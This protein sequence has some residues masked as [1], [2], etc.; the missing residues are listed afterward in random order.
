MALVLLD[1]FYGDHSGSCWHY[2]E[3]VEA[4]V[5]LLL[6]RASGEQ[7]LPAYH[8]YFLVGAFAKSACTSKLS[9]LLS[10]DSTNDESEKS[11]SSVFSVIVLNIS[12]SMSVPITSMKESSLDTVALTANSLAASSL[13]KA[14]FGPCNGPPA[15]NLKSIGST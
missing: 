4:S 1:H 2:F 11:G 9:S 3:I 8:N 14:N 13:T 5:L 10:S 7:R 12:L 6:Q 15:L